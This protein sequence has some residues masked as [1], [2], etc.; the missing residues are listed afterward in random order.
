MSSA[1]LFLRHNISG[2]RELIVQN[3]NSKMV[4]YYYCNLGYNSGAIDAPSS[5]GLLRKF[6]AFSESHLV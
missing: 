4:I 5:G 1:L 2:E 6:S 3:I